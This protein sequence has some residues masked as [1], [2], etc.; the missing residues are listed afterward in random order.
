[1]SCTYKDQLIETRDKLGRQLQEA[2]GCN[3]PEYSAQLCKEIECIQNL[4]ANV[5][6]VDENEQRYFDLTS[7]AMT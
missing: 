4:L 7:Q 6:G 1:M 5:V 3:N 2:V